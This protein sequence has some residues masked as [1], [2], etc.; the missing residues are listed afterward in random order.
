MYIYRTQFWDV[1]H[2]NLYCPC[3]YTAHSSGTLHTQTFESSPVFGRRRLR[4]RKSTEHDGEKKL[5]YWV[6]SL[7]LE[8]FFF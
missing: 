7:I 6:F 4:G 3:T 1:T 8:G 5:F 2:S